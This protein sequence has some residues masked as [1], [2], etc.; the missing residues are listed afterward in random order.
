[1]TD[2]R[3][4]VITATDI[5]PDIT[6]RSERHLAPPTGATSLVSNVTLG[7]C[8][9]A[10]VAMLV[11]G[12]AKLASVRGFTNAL[13]TH[14]LITSAVASI[15]ALPLAVVQVLIGIALI[16]PGW[17]TAGALGAALWFGLATFG[18]AVG[19]ANN[20]V[21]WCDCWSAFDVGRFDRNH[22]IAN[23]VGAGGA[24]T[25]AALTAVAKRAHTSRVDTV[26]SESEGVY[27][28]ED[29]AQSV[30]SDVRV[31]IREHGT[32]RSAQRPGRQG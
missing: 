7:L 2:A 27:G 28:E 6:H 23:A 16:I 20:Q 18:A 10:A 31:G 8:V 29:N 15:A 11:L 4:H 1:M 24:L 14:P 12:G 17:R 19:F 25:L 13:E 22:M 30:G 32:R 26:L 9:C 3:S 5:D 21:I